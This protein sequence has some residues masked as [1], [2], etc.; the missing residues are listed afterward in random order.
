MQVSLQGGNVNLENKEA[1]WGADDIWRIFWMTAI[2][3][4]LMPL[5]RSA[6]ALKKNFSLA[7]WLHMV[8][9]RR[10]RRLRQRHKK[11]ACTVLDRRH[12]RGGEAE[13]LLWCHP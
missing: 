13:A 7:M 2:F 3:G 1:R 4:A 9:E 10:P 11:F 12:G 5:S 6:W 8:S